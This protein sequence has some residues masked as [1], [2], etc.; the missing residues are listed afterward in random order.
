MTR[1][2]IIS[3]LGDDWRRYEALV[4]D[5][6]RSDIDILNTVNSSLLANSGKQLRPMLSLL[7]ARACGAVN[8][9]S[10]KFA[11][12]AELLHNA[13]LLHDDVADESSLRRGRPTLSALMGPSSAVLVGDFWLARA[14]NMIMGTAHQDRVIPLFARTLSDL[15][16]GEMLQ[17]QKA[18]TADTTEQDYLRIVYCKTASLFETSCCSAAISADA[19]P[20]LM[21]AARRYGA[22]VGIAF[23]IRDDIFDY[24]DDAGIGK[25]LGIDLKER[26][27]TMPLLGAL[28]NVSNGDAYR[29][30]IR[31]IPE[32]PENCAR[33][34]RFVLENGGL[35]Y[36]TSRL[37]DFIDEALAALE[38]FPRTEE[39]DLLAG[40]ARFNAIRKK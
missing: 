16:E 20:E 21:D 2:N 28:K 30:M 26:K 27:I 29:E 40:L 1:E 4:R 24:N 13:T 11:A 10:L 22:A 19:S 39:R 38:L 5:A 36:A 23:Q 14:V 7:M 9:E 32:H 17:L 31:Q 3:L 34:H 33:L 18:G 12:A 25:P 8:S 35:E 15:A 37:D 6:L